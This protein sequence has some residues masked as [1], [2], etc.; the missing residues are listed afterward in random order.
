[1]EEA[2]DAGDTMKYRDFNSKQLA[3]KIIMNTFYGLL[4]DSN[5]PLYDVAIASTITAMGRL[6]LTTA[7]NVALSMGC[8]IIYGDTDSLFII[9]K[10]DRN[11]DVSVMLADTAAF[12][13]KC[14]D[15]INTAVE[16]ITGTQ[17]IK[18]EFDKLLSPMVMLGKKG[19]YGQAYDVKTLKPKKEL[20]ASGLISAK[21]GNSNYT[22]HIINLV[23]ARTL[24]LTHSETLLQVVE[25]MVH[26]LYDDIRTQPVDC[27]IQHNKYNKGK[28]SY[29]N[30]FITECEHTYSLLPANVPS[31]IHNAYRVPQ[32][33]ELF[34]YVVTVPADRYLS[35][36][37]LKP[38]KISSRMMLYTVFQMG[39]YKLDYD[40]Y[41]EGIIKKLARFIHGGIADDD[42]DDDCDATER[43][44]VDNGKSVDKVLQA[45]AIK[46]LMAI[47]NAKTPAVNHNIVRAHRKVVAKAFNANGCQYIFH[48]FNHLHDTMIP[49]GSTILDIILQYMQR[50]IGGFANSSITTD[51]TSPPDIA[52]IRQRITRHE[53]MLQRNSNLIVA[54]YAYIQN[55]GITCTIDPVYK[56]FNGILLELYRLYSMA[57]TS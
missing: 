5:F 27:F 51:M 21:R 50:N 11:D 56:E 26:F 32:P 3:V 22:K 43:T 15:I 52:D 30:T 45:E 13:H 12:A 29:I 20:Y 37:K 46:H 16:A 10:I 54:M 40:Y 35:D 53:R 14:I 28:R 19:Y 47:V 44:D 41:I 2:Y 42:D 57:H 6:C 48:I 9:P 4:G 1:M 18:M 38:S 39:N 49:P 31:N 55:I 8:K 33:G 17:Y 23:I 7:K 25:N 34:Q 24:D 36:G